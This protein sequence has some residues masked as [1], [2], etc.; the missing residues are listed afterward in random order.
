MDRF[1]VVIAS[2]SFEL[3][4][5]WR[6]SIRRKAEKLAEFHPRITACRVVV[7]EPPRHHRSG[8]LYTVRVD[9]EVPRGL[10]VIDRE[11]AATLEEAVSRSFDAAGR[12][13]EDFVRR[14]R[15]TARRVQWPPEGLVYEIFSEGGYG[16]LESEDGRSVYFHRNSVLG[17]LFERLTPGSRVRFVERMGEKGPQASTVAVV[18]LAPRADRRRRRGSPRGVSAPA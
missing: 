13:L 7:E 3:S 12:R 6:E 1:P 4:G 11:S 16:F 5:F 14:H 2:R 15:D 8:A 10:I 17:G 9:V 18:S